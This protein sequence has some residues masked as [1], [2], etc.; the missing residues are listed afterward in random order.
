[1]DEGETAA[2][3]VIEPDLVKRSSVEKNLLGTFKFLKL[4]NMARVPVIWIDGFATP[5]T[6]GAFF[7]AAEVPFTTLDCPDLNMFAHNGRRKLTFVRS[8]LRNERALAK[9]KLAEESGELSLHDRLKEYDV[10]MSIAGLIPKI[11]KDLT[12]GVGVQLFNTSKIQLLAVHSLIKRHFDDGE[13]AAAPPRFFVITSDTSPEERAAANDAAEGHAGLHGLELQPVCV[14]TTSAV[15]GGLNFNTT[16]HV[17]AFI[18]RNLGN[19]Q[20]A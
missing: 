6:T 20:G 3:M 10:T 1:M 15:G 13:T 17:Y 2:Y 19:A 4:A 8:Y 12:E 14:A 18:F 11:I 9:N 7:R 5:E 16:T